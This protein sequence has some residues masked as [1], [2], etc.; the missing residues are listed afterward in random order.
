MWWTGA[1]SLRDYCETFKHNVTC[2][3]WEWSDPLPLF[4]QVF[5]IPYLMLKR[6]Y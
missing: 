5:L 3:E 2:C 6:G 4:L 1:M